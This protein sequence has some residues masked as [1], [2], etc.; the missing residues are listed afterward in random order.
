M[1][2]LATLLALSMTACAMDVGATVEEIEVGP[3]G[4]YPKDQKFQTI[5]T[6]FREVDF[7]G[8]ILGSTIVARGRV[9][10]IL[11]P[12]RNK[13]LEM[14]LYP[15]I[16]EVTDNI[17]GAEGKK[18]FTWYVPGG[19]TGGFVADYDITKFMKVD[20][21]EDVVVLL[22]E[23]M[24]P[25]S[26]DSVIRVDAQDDAELRQGLFPEKYNVG[27]WDFK[28]KFKVSYADLKQYILNNHAEYLERVK[29]AP[30]T[31]SKELPWEAEVAPRLSPEI[32]LSYL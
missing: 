21:G 25:S 22:G 1:L 8:I 3:E 29:N 4:N 5:T 26:I 2:L 27:Y 20:P 19:E 13:K 10:K 9:V 12:I 18:Q 7:D 16:F 32:K 11:K 6:T 31:E 14:N 30:P 15:V 17:Y 24:I 28:S 23:V